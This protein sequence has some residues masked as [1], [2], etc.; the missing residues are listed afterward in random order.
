MA[1][2]L[3][4]HPSQD[5]SGHK[6]RFRLGF[7]TRNI[8]PIL[9]SWAGGT[10]KPSYSK[11]VVRSFMVLF[12]LPDDAPGSWISLKRWISRLSAFWSLSC[13]SLPPWWWKNRLRFWL[14][15]KVLG[16]STI[17]VGHAQKFRSHSTFFFRDFL[18]PRNFETSHLV[19]GTCIILYMHYRCII[20][21]HIYCK[22]VYMYA[23]NEYLPCFC[24]LYPFCSHQDLAR[25][26][27]HAAGS[28]CP[29]AEKMWSKVKTSNVPI[30]C[31]QVSVAVMAVFF[32]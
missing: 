24:L 5:A 25:Q 13:W 7:P 9:V 15:S 12:G 19:G 21:I 17:Q 26:E 14:N 10:Q 6:W 27:R 31:W 23:C 11:Q 4:C 1:Y 20:Y 16:G 30:F 8:T 18:G 28:F 3:G 32:V 22:I 29:F 2:I